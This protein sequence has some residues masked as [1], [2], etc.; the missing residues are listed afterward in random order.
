VRVLGFLQERW[1][2]RRW[3]GKVGREH[4]KQGISLESVHERVHD[5]MFDSV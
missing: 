2:G 1:A 3:A 5:T 4:S